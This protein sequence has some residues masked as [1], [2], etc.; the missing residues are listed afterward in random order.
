MSEPI[1]WDACQGCEALSRSVQSLRETRDRLRAEL[2]AMRDQRDRYLTEREQWRDETV[3]LR[4]ELDE[5]RARIAA[6][7]EFADCFGVY[8]ECVESKRSPECIANE[9]E[10]TKNAID[11]AMEG[12]K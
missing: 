1:Q 7:Q 4:A 9:L 12:R 5:A 11:A 10:R 8:R 6:L 2:A 3:A